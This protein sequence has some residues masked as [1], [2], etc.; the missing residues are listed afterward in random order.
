M[1]DV[2]SASATPC[3]TCG[4]H[5]PRT[6]EFY[7]VDFTCIGGLKRQCRSCANAESRQRYAA[8]P[9]SVR[10]RVRTRRAEMAAYWTTQWAEE[11]A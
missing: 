11:A 4:H 6:R 7:H 10:E 3:R 8:N 1:S 9:A 5:W 2:P